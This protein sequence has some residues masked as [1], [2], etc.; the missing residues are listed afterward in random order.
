MTATRSINYRDHRPI[1]NIALVQGKLPR[2]L[3]FETYQLTPFHKP[4]NET[5]LPS[6]IRFR[7]I[8]HARRLDRIP[9]VESLITGAQPAPLPQIASQDIPSLNNIPLPKVIMRHVIKPHTSLLPPDSPLSPLNQLSSFSLQSPKITGL[10]IELRGR[11]GTR[12]AKQYYAVGRLDTSDVGSAFV[13]FGK[14]MYT[15]SKGT[16]GVKVWVGYGQ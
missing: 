8:Q 15:H 13:D 1:F 11:R 7:A 2:N 14:A 5:T 9:T 16:S 10:R 3:N 12:S 4:Q 6:S